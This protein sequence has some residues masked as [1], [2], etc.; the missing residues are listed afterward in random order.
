M[1]DTVSQWLDNAGRYELLTDEQTLILSR[2][3]QSA[4]G[5]ARTRAL[6]KLCLHNLRLIVKVV[7]MS[8]HRRVTLTMNSEG[9][10]DL[11]QQGYFGL[12][13]AAEK[14]D[15][16]RGY[17]FSTYAT[18]WIRQAVSR[19]MMAGDNPIRI[20]EATLRE[21]VYRNRHGVPSQNKGVPIDEKLLTA[22]RK[23]QHVGSIDV[24]VEE[25]SETQLAD[26]LAT[27]HSLTHSYEPRNGFSFLKEKMDEAGIDEPTQA[28]MLAYAKRNNIMMAAYKSKYKYSQASKRIKEVKQILADMS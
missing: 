24:A 6:N 21:V 2:K 9:V 11:L 27:E 19:H 15:P 1:P 10:L 13:R 5:P 14:F 22:A 4:E 17:R 20:P 12:R 7:K 25:G 16:S 26:V 8:T 3:I 18:P 23:A 28:L